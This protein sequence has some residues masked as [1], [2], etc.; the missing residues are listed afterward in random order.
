M[1]EPVTPG[2]PIVLDDDGDTY[3]L[4]VP[5]P[6]DAV[7]VPDLGTLAGSLFEDAELGGELR[8]GRRTVRVLPVTPELAFTTLERGAQ[9]VRPPDAA[10]IAHACGVGPGR[11]VVEGGA[12]SGALTAYLAFLV[13]DEGQVHAFD[14]R[15]DHLATA[16]RN[17]ERLDLDARVTWHE[18]DLAE[19][20]VRAEVFVADLPEPEAVI[21][22][23]ERCLVPGG[24]LAVYAPIVGQVEAA[25][26]RVAEHAFE[27]A[28]TL[29]QLTRDWV[30]H[31]RGARPGF[32][33]LGHTGFLTFATRV[34]EEGS[35]TRD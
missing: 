13:G 20:D 14:V 30:V 31:D 2:T 26:E 15:E 8:L 3:L 22:A 7:E 19:A 11:T 33:M 24:R 5:E 21:E 1:P 4:R 9:V 28:A 18:A 12:G 27:R 34:L 10:R 25:R 32:E 23:A 6:G 17:L 16:R 35:G 29:E